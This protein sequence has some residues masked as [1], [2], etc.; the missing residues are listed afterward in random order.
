MTNFV[1]GER[2]IMRGRESPFL[3][4]FVSTIFA[5]LCVTVGSAVVVRS[6]AQG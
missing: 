2:R 4:Y 3:T 5:A 6:A 1:L